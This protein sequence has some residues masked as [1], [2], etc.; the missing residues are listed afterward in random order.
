M[1]NINLQKG[2]EALRIR[3]SCGV[4]GAYLERGDAILYLYWGML[5]QNHRGHQSHGFAIFNAEISCHT[6][7]GLIPPSEEGNLAKG[8]RGRIGIA[9][10]RYA[11]ASG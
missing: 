8:L 10:V 5:A 1:F 2:G 6:G 4:F 9:N 11:R 7:L 3:E